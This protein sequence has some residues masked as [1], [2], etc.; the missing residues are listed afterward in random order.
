M[1]FEEDG[2]KVV[3]PLDP[4][5]VPRYTDPMNNNMEGENLNQL[6]DV[7]VGMREDYINPTID[8]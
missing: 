4:Y 8:G 3:Q 5:E 2:I 7:T 1:T 6:Y